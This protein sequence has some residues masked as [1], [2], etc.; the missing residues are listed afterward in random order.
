MPFT[1]EQAAQAAKSLGVDIEKEKFTAADLAAGMDAEL[2]RHGTKSAVMNITD[3][4]PV[5]TAQLAMANLRETPLYYSPTVGKSAW[6]RSLTKGAKQQG[7]KTEFKTLKFELEKYDEET[8]IFS[9]YAAVFGNVDSGGDVIEPGAFTKTI[10]EGTERVKI[11]VLHNDC[12]LPIG[13]PLELREDSHGLYIKGKVSDTSMGRDVKILLQDKVLNEMSIGYDP[14]VFDYD[15]ESGVRHLREVKLWEVSLVTW[16]MNPEAVVT[17]YK[18]REAADRATQMAADLVSDIKE[19]RKIS[20]AR[21]KSLKE[22]SDTMKGA[23]KVLD[24][25]IQEVEGEKSMTTRRKLATKRRPTKPTI[26]ITF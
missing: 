11:L 12:W 6:E 16:A 7:V 14:I 15:S 18:A 4:D 25:L 23:V 8:G 5:K 20:G 17:G 13:R 26:E 10:A 24:A 19:G 9:G 3:D 22:A 21:L 2:E 1:A